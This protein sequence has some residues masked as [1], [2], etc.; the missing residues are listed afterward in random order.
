MHEFMGQ[1]PVSS[2]VVPVRML[3]DAEPRHCWESISVPPGCPLQDTCA[4]G[5]YDDSDFGAAHGKD[6]VVMRDG[7][8]GVADIGKEDVVG[9]IR[10][11]ARKINLNR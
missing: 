4:P 11:D 8:C 5:H 1:D 7:V 10:L 3:A 9:Q 6:T 2:E